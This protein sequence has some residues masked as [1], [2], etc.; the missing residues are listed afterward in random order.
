MRR[1]A[2]PA[3]STRRSTS[4]RR[5]PRRVRQILSIHTSEMPL[6]PSPSG[7]LANCDG[8]DR[9][10]HR[11]RP[12]A[13]GREAGL[14]AARRLT[15]PWR[16]GGARGS[17]SSSARRRA[18][19]RA[20]GTGEVSPER[21]ARA[22][23]SRTAARVGRPRRVEDGPTGPRRRRCRCFRPGT[24][25]RE[26]VLLHGPSGNGKSVLVQSLAAH[27]GANLVLV[28]GSTIFTQWLGES[29]AA[30]SCAVPEG[31]RGRPVDR[32]AGAPRRRG[33]APGG[34]HSRVGE[35]PGPVGSAVLGGRGPSKR[36]ILVIGITDRPDDIDPALARAGGSASMPRSASP[37]TN[38]GAAHPAG[39]SRPRRGRRTPTGRA[40]AGP[41]RRR[42]SAGAERGA[43]R[44]VGPGRTRHRQ[45]AEARHRGWRH[46]DDM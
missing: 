35:Q 42:S 6:P 14:V 12:D 22:A 4:A 29:E 45:T 20:P 5:K 13:P 31:A 1:S 34:G 46:R 17:V 8:R 11:R 15:G 25:R 3:D 41:P 27:V 10:V 44:R 7:E 36:G 2:V 32:G 28:D 16:G 23:G 21:A 40:A 39:W 24:G 26:G 9:R 19:R 37:T 33:P 18:R 30:H 43:G 38:V